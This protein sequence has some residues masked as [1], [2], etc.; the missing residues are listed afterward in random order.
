ML[1]LLVPQ[2]LTYHKTLFPVVPIL[3]DDNVGWFADVSENMAVFIIKVK[4][5][6][7]QSCTD[8]YSSRSQGIGEF[9][10][11]TCRKANQM[12]GHYLV[13]LP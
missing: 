5:L 1:A 13:T 7:Q 9:C 4:L 8:I 2:L 3:S 10:V 11:P 12:P 6:K